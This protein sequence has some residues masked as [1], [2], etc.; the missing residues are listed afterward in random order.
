MPTL[1]DKSLTRNLPLNSDVTNGCL[2]AAVEATSME[3]GAESGLTRHLTYGHYSD[4]N[5]GLYGS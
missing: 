5:W 1:H 2:V 3:S 4:Q